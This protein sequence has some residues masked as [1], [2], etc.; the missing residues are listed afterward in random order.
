MIMKH[1]YRLNLL[2]TA[3]VF[4]AA[5]YAACPNAPS[6]LTL[7]FNVESG[8]I[9]GKVTAPTTSDWTGEYAPLE[10]LS[11][12]IVERAVEPED[13]FSETEF[14]EAVTFTNPT[15]GAVLEFVD[16]YEVEPGI[17]YVYRAMAIIDDEISN[18]YA[19]RKTVFAGILPGDVRNL[20]GQTAKGVSP[21]TLTFEIPDVD[22]FD[23][24]L[25]VP[26]TGICIKR[27][28]NFGEIETLALITDIQDSSA[29]MTYVD[30][31]A[32]TGH[33]YF[34]YISARTQYGEGDASTIKVK[35]DKDIPG[36]IKSVNAELVG[37]SVVITW[38]A[39]QS[40]ESNGYMDPEETFYTIQ[41]IING[42]E[43][44]VLASEY[45][46]TSFTDDRSELT[47]EICYTYRVTPGNAQGMNTY[48]QIRDVIA[49]P[50]S[51]YPYAE[52]FNGGLDWS[53]TPEHNWQS[54]SN[55]GQSNWGAQTYGYYGPNYSSV[56]GANPEVTSDGFA[57]A[58]YTPYTDAELKEWYT[59][60][61]ISMK[62]AKTPVL[63]FY[64]IGLP[65]E[66][67]TTL[68]V[69]V[70]DPSGKATVL[71]TI[72][73]MAENYGWVLHTHDLNDWKGCDWIKL[74]FV[75]EPGEI[76][77]PAGFDLV[78][79]SDEQPS[80]IAQFIQNGV[81]YYVSD[82]EKSEVTVAGYPG[83]DVNAVIPEKVSYKDK[84]Y[85]VVEIADMAFYNMPSLAS[86]EIPS[87]VRRIG[88]MAFWGAQDLKSITIP[89]GVKTMGEGV[90]LYCDY[91]ESVELPETLESMDVA[92]FSFCRSLKSITLPSSLTEIPRN[93]FAFCVSLEEALLPETL[94]TIGSQAFS[95]AMA[96]KEAEIPSNVTY[97]G[98]L[99]FEETSLRSVTIPAGIT[100]LFSG[101]FQNCASLADVTFCSQVPPTVSS[102]AFSGIAQPC[103]GH[104]PA[105]T[106][107]AYSNTPGLENID[108]QTSGIQTIDP[109]IG[110]VES[111]YDMTGKAVDAAS[112]RGP[113]IL[114][115]RE[116]NQVRASKVVR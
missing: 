14:S 49:G 6:D 23:D 69:E 44:V 32:E 43:N 4:S 113:A 82:A 61:R 41:R 12:I 99:A 88:S 13:Y 93:A 52:D 39:P 26:V 58:Q 27:N 11:S 21:V 38:D 59:T 47:E 64:A 70:L 78:S 86:V 36:Q 112:Y 81:L 98:S 51:A 18:E 10:Y 91:L 77:A 74:R 76:P 46:G 73:V 101:T 84:E 29:A 16:P 50:P 55:M 42:G 40:G 67:T 108:F 66:T 33:E 68:A 54:G 87:S 35:V 100:D 48:T 83:D 30:E 107:D 85:T 37:E 80:S 53:K 90:F 105:G 34:Y 79:V 2:M 116:G 8:K 1:S 94:T 9:V 114:I 15:P 28:E 17:R 62:E 65:V 31:S 97:I 111:L 72:P 102:S 106:E 71:E 109:T 5:T 89:E 92:V 103:T 95:C 63:S 22:I 115:I 7:R 75:S 3:C 19:C 20:K 56:S 24:P 110:Q 60:G 96:L 25:P 104:C 57:W 45:K